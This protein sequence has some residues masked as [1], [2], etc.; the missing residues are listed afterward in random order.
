[1]QNKKKKVVIKSLRNLQSDLYRFA[2]SYVKNESDALDVV[3]ESAIK[4]LKNYHSIKDVNKV[5][6][7]L[8]TIIRNT[9]LTVLNQKKNKYH[10]SLRDV[11]EPSAEESIEKSESIYLKDTLKNL[12]DWK[13]ELIVMKF[14]EDLTFEEMASILEMN[15]STVKSRYYKVI[16]E[17]KNAYER[18]AS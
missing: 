5:K 9:A 15:I 16:N 17:L 18:S 1:M 11:E 14:F 8:F 10:L 7:W 6:S 12:E 13:R 3:Q 4:A 2:L